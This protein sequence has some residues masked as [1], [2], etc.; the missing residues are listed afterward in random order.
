MKVSAL[1]RARA[2]GAA[3]VEVLVIVGVVLVLGLLAVKLLGQ[4]SSE[5]AEKEA[6]CI[7]SFACGSGSPRGSGPQD[8]ASLV[9][10]PGVVGRPGTVATPGRPANPRA[11]LAAANSAFADA[12][13]ALAAVNSRI[14]EGGRTPALRSERAAARRSVRDAEAAYNAAGQA[15]LDQAYGGNYGFLAHNWIDIKNTGPFL[16]GLAA[17]TPRGVVDTVTDVG[18]LIGW[19][20]DR[21][22]GVPRPPADPAAERAGRIAEREQYVDH[23]LRRIRDGAGANYEDGVYDGRVVLGGVVLGEGIGLAAR[24]TLA[25]GGA[26]LRAGASGERVA[27]AAAARAVSAAEVAPAL[28]RAAA[29]FG[30]EVETFPSLY[31]LD[32]RPPAQI[33]REGFVPNPSKPAGTATAH[34]ERG[35]TGTRDYVSTSRAEANPYNT[36]NTDF[37]PPPDVTNPTQ[38]QFDLMQRGRLEPRPITYTNREYRLVNVQGVAVPNSVGV[39]AEREVLIGQAAP[40][41]VAAYREIRTV[42]NWERGALVDEEGFAVDYPNTLQPLRRATVE[43]G[44]WMPMPRP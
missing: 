42:Q 6:T 20:W 29:E 4:S 31:R 35:S 5:Q 8:L 37:L 9:G 17:G 40:N 43:V 19:A 10:T 11:V 39:A 7:K 16:A 26:A 38:A 15:I 18:H 36:A 3:Y 24:G 23:E 22:T 27:A 2:R 32:T 1:S 44:E 12:E 13:D 21:V 30:G 14:A 25:V 28:G 34:V 41:Q 33:A